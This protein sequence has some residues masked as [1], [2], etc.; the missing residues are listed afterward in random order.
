M[1]NFKR[2]FWSCAGDC[3]ERSQE[4]FREKSWEKLWE[5]FRESLWEDAWRNRWRNSMGNSAT[6]SEKYPEKNSCR[7]PGISYERN[8]RNMRDSGSNISDKI[9]AKR[10][11]EIPV[12]YS[13]RNLSDF[14]N[15]GQFSKR[16]PGMNYY[17][18]IKMAVGTP[19]RNSRRTTKKNV[20][21]CEYCT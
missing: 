19:R 6:P 9:H 13:R 10:F 1:N 15:S 21:K 7:N 16:K 18:I 20:E 11:I 12:K 14:R 5:K 8:P 2:H 3:W 4:K 17:N